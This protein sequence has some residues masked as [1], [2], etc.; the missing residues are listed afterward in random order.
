MPTKRSSIARLIALCALSSVGPLA[1]S[2]HAQAF[3]S[4]PITIVVPFAP[5]GATDILT[6][7]LAEKMAPRLGQPIVIDNRAGAAGMIGT[8][9]VAKAAPDGH[10]I[11]LGGTGALSVNPFLYK[12]V[13]YD[14]QKDF[15]PV[16]L[17]TVL[18]NLFVVPQSLP[19]STVAQFNAY[20]KAQQGKISY[21]T[22][23]PGTPPHLGAEL[24]NTMAGIKSTAIPYK[25]GALA[26]QDLVAGQTQ[27][28]FALLPEVLQFVKA[29]RLKALA[30]TTFE[31][32]PDHPNLPTVAE[33]VPGFEFTSWYGY[34]APA[35]TPKDVIAKLNDAFNH[36]LADASVKEK[37]GNMGFQ[38]AGGKP[39]KMKEI[40]DSSAAKWKKVIDDNKITID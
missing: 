3:P 5:G 21:G 20:A 35:G 27:F 25:G 9:Y 19:V 12:K 24:Y 16:V 1:A 32:L 14:V 10:T 26:V 34:L 36:A 39:E 13:A 28:M 29:G 11:L 30:T 22:P 8:A 17:A 2:A 40:V 6:R 4:R 15:A 31:R 18:P 38:I 37:L 23:G 7:T 33:T